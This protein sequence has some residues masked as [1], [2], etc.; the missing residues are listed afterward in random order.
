MALRDVWR[1]LS[2]QIFGVTRSDWRTR[3]G[4]NFKRLLRTASSLAERYGLAE[5]VD[6]ARKLLRK[7]IEGAAVGAYEKAALDAAMAEEA[8][9]RTRIAQRTAEAAIERSTLENERLRSEI[10]RNRADVRRTE[11]EALARFMETMVRCGVAVSLRGARIDI[12]PHGGVIV[13]EDLRTVLDDE[14][15]PATL[16]D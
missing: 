12:V 4:R 10:E 9:T 7:R 14:Q 15:D 1:A 16:R 5:R 6:D 8:R 3:P 13:V 2:A 11:T